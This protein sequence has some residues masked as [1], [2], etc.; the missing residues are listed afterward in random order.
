MHAA[1]VVV[2]DVQRDG[3][4]QVRQF[5]YYQGDVPRLPDSFCLTLVVVGS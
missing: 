4:F 2:S 5:L 1:K 3:R